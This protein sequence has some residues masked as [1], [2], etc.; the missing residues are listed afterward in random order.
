MSRLAPGNCSDSILLLAAI[1]V[2]L[3]V[4]HLAAADRAVVS[5]GS[6]SST[7]T[8]SGGVVPVAGDNAFVGST[9]PTGALSNATVTLFQDVTAG[10][11]YLGHDTGTS[12]HLDL[13]NFTFTAQDL[14][15]GFVGTGSITRGTG[16]LD[17]SRFDIR[18]GNSFTL[19][20]NDVVRNSIDIA[21]GS[22]LTLS[23]NVNVANDIDLRDNG[24]VLNAQ[25]FNIQANQFL[26]GWNNT[27]TPQLLNRGN[28]TVNE[29][30]VRGQD[31]QLTAADSVG[32]FI[33]RT[34]N[35]TLNSGVVLGRLD[36]R[37]G[38]TATTAATSNVTAYVSVES[39]STLTLGA[40]LVL[41]DKLNMFGTGTVVNAAGKDISASSQ[42]LLGWD[43]VGAELQNRGKLTTNELLVRGQDFQLT[44]NDAVNRLI[45]NA[46]TTNL[47]AV[48]V[49]GRLDLLGGAT[50]TTA[51]TGNITNY[52]H[53][54]AGS[55]LTLG[56]NLTLSDKLNIRGAG[57]IV[58][59]AGKNITASSQLLFGWDSGGTPELQNVGSINVGELLIGSGAQLSLASGQDTTGRIYIR[60][61]ARLLASASAAGT[62]LTLTR[63]STSELDI[64]AG[65]RMTLGLD[66]SNPGWAFRWA[67]P[68]GGDHVADLNG[69]ITLG[70]I[71]FQDNI[72]FSITSQADGYTYIT[73]APVPEPASI[74]GLWAI[75]AGTAAGCRR[76][77]RA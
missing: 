53:V 12:G 77:R 34:G 4:G 52:V 13:S 6:W 49:L 60:D 72:S 66:G 54:E 38:A 73:M 32:R 23:A 36:L 56:A 51:A 17:V 19:A 25:G 59:S 43:G 68:T 5:S 10:N 42:I 71:D 35:T 75:A 28:L 50:G 64:E 76:Y 26:L 67:N 9:T 61:N 39:G 1:C 57:T 46:G 33:L 15:F 44:A 16:H 37:D 63:T 62:G 21:S 65:S 18:N 74:L 14:Y 29:L 58:N 2:L 11:V 40:N 24:T 48:V 70:R 27:G 7:S 41:S 45:I 55:T 20:A 30:L 22:T 47:G 31:F 8:W 3:D 69:L